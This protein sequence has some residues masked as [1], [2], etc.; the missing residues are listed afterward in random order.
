MQLTQHFWLEEFLYSETAARMGRLIVPNAMQLANIERLCVQ[1]LEPI[2]SLLGRPMF[3]TSGLRPEW[4]NIAIGGSSNSA[5]MDGL[6][7]DVKVVGMAP[8]EF[9][10]WI[11][12][13]GFQVDQVIEEYSQWTH[14][15]TSIAPPR[16]QYLTA[17]IID[18]RT[19]YEAL[20]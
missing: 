13:S 14:V 10:R 15:A 11:R 3:I 17:S 18:R 9:C 1:V 12:N 7:A 19:V 16:N 5:H 8:R 6:A 20:A 2:R 4:L